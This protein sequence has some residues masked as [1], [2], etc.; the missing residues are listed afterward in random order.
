MIRQLLKDDKRFQCARCLKLYRHKHILKRHI[1]FECG[2]EP[3]FHCSLCGVLERHV[4]NQCGR[5]YKHKTN[6]LN[7]KREECNKPPSYFCPVAECKRGFKK[8]QHLQRHVLIHGNDEKVM[9]YL[10]KENEKKMER[11][12]SF[13]DLSG[14]SLNLS[15]NLEGNTSSI[16]FGAPSNYSQFVSNFPQLRK[17][18]QDKAKQDQSA[19][20]TPSPSASGL[21]N[22]SSAGPNLDQSNSNNSFYMYGAR[23]M[24]TVNSPFD[25]TIDLL[26]PSRLFSKPS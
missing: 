20:F 7:H 15:K 8:K 18:D 14:R 6:L 5:S 9:E 4:C 2:V 12:L 26:D 16:A 17:P 10:R 21:K 13:S 24:S 25:F 3:Q 23:N 1:E 11:R 22:N 19:S